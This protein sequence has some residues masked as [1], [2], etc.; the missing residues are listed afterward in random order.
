LFTAKTQGAQRKTIFYSG[1]PPQAEALK[2]EFHKIGC[3]IL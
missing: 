1:V 2:T 3:P